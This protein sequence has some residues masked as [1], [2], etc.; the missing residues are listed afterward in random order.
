MPDGYG[1]ARIPRSRAKRVLFS[2]LE[3]LSPLQNGKSI[4]LKDNY[5][6][7]MLK[8]PCTGSEML[9]MTGAA[10]SPE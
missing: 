9:K 4:A 5:L 2:R 1:V 10:A 3:S 6:A 8:R 7:E